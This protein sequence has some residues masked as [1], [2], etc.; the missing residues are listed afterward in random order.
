MT[1]K[2]NPLSHFIIKTEYWFYFTK[3]AKK[4]FKNDLIFS[5]RRKKI[6]FSLQS[7]SSGNPKQNTFSQGY[8]NS[9]ANNLN[10]STLRR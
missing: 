6:S 5:E 10:E 1:I 4:K 2:G 3:Y 9:I 7:Y 8:G